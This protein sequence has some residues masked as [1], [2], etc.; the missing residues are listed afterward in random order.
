MTNSSL[1][2]SSPLTASHVSPICV[3]AAQSSVPL[4]ITV[5]LFMAPVAVMAHSTGEPPAP[6]RTCPNL[7]LWSAA[8]ETVHDAASPVELYW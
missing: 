8:V 6:E 3:S 4:M 7:N 1:T 5:A 2:S